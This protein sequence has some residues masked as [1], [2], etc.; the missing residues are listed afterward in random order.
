MANRHLSRS[1][2]LQTLFEWDFNGN[3][4]TTIPEIM[5]RDIEEFASGA[6]D[7]DFIKS[8]AVGVASKRKELDKIIEKAAPDWPLDKIANVDRNVLRIGL[9]EL[10]FSDRTQVPAKVAI[11]EAIELAKTY[12]GGTSGKFINGVLGAVYKELGEPGKDEE[13]KRKK[14]DVEVPYEEMPIEKL[15]GA[16]VYAKEGSSLYLALVHDVFGKWTLS[17]G[18]TVEGESDSDAVKRKVLEEMGANIKNVFDKLGENE[19]IATHPTDGKVRKQV[20]YY[21]AEAEYKDLRLGNSGGLDDAKWFRLSE[22]L[23]LNFYDD[24]LPIVTKALNILAAKK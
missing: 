24:I 12:G 13:S 22:I 4:N 6:G 15:V 2:V 14:K 3:D 19:Y 7:D 16:V 8:L 10:L 18:H 20:I 1:I 23:D 9:Y 21:M 11:N 5:D 17:K